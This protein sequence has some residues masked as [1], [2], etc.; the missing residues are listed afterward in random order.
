MNTAYFGATENL[1]DWECGHVLTELR[2][3]RFTGNPFEIVTVGEHP[4]SVPTMGGLRVEVD[5]TLDHVDPRPGDVLILAGGLAWSEDRGGEAF[6][7]LA[8]ELLD[9]GGH[10]AAICDATMGLARAGLLDDR[11]HTSAAAEYLATSGYAGGEHYVEARAVVG[12]GVVTAGPDSPVQLAAETLRMLGLADDATLEAYE[13]VF[14]GGDATAY[15]ALMQA[16]T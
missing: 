12:D 1:A 10:V 4:G 8:R 3:G 6:V 14:S 7:A 2:T 13:R 15:P 9:A 5:R 11:P 16:A